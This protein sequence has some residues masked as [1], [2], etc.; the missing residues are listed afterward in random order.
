MSSMVA[1]SLSRS[2]DAAS[3]SPPLLSARIFITMRSLSGI[4][5]TF[6]RMISLPWAVSPAT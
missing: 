4:F 2:A 5:S 1:R 3:H 6:V